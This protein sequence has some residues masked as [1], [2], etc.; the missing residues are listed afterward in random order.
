MQPAKIFLVILTLAFVNAQ[1]QQQNANPLLI[2]SN[3]PLAF[4]KVT[5]ETIRDAGTAVIKLSDDRINKITRVPAGKRTDVNTLLATDELLYELT[6]LS[7]KLSLISQTYMSDAARDAANE[8][9]EKI[10]TYSNDLYLNDGLYNALKQFASS[11]AAKQIKP[12]HKKF[13][14]ETL[15]AFEKNGMKLRVAQREELKSINQK[16]ISF[17]LQFDKNI[18]EY[19]DSV[20]FTEAQL[21]GVPVNTKAKWKRPDGNYIV[22]VNGPNSIDIARYADNSDTRK[23][24]FLAYNNRAFPKNIQALDSLFYYRQQLADKLGFNSYAAYAVIDKMAKSPA[25]VWNFENDLIAKLAPNVT[26][27]LAELKQIKQRYEPASTGLNNWDI[28]YYTKKLLDSKYQLNTDEVKQ[29]FEMNNTLRGMFTVYQKLFGIEIKETQAV[30][31]WHE[32]VRTYEMF[33]DGKKIGSFLLDLFPRPNK[34]THFAC[35]P[36]NEYRIANNKE[37]LPV[38]ALI[39]NFPEGNENEPSLLNHSDVITLFHE[40]GHLVHSMLGRSDIAIQGPFFVKGDFTEAPSQFLENWV[41]EYDALKLFARHYKT[42]QTLPLSLFNKMKQAQLFQS[43][44]GTMR[45]VYLGV[46]DFTY[47]DKYNSIREKDINKVS[48]ELFSLNQLPFVPGNH[49]I[50]SFTHLNGYAANYYGYLWSK[51]FAQDMFSAFK[52]NGVMDAKTGLRYRKEILEKAA[53]IDEMQMLRNFL[54][55]EPN[56]NAFLE[57]LGLK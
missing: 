45:Q 40:F 41:W 14:D 32:K 35:F 7:A 13:L 39:C 36:I 15:V 1:S 23:T 52:K 43:G 2:H 42:G 53:T 19:K 54:G 20:K 6:D 29:Y 24:M 25:T 55:R 50:A 27:D 47:H 31:K 49:F 17:G 46:L 28:S 16:V 51:V 21:A 8:A 10:S 38:S 48:E 56:A 57:T 5:A 4:D 11:P 44:A 26:R 37:V 22:Y 12:N 30:P 34:Y 9:S 3:A 33:K 18:A